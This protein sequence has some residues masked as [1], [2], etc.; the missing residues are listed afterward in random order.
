MSGFAEVVDCVQQFDYEE[1]VEL[2]ELTNKYIIELKREQIVLAHNE[3]IKEN[4]NGKLHFSSD[5][6]ELNSIL[7]SI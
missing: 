3:S 2:N 6:N 1:L 5:F 7:D 4:N